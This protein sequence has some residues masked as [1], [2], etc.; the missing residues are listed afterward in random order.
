[1]F[2]VRIRRGVA[3]VALCP[4][5]REQAQRE[6]KQIKRAQR[7]TETSQLQATS[8]RQP[9]PVGQPQAETSVIRVCE[10]ASVHKGANHTRHHRTFTIAA[11]QRYADRVRG[12]RAW[13]EG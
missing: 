2:Y 9:Q 7:Q 13:P 10:F 12:S 4:P 5:S 8:Q 1:M 11:L 3:Y 6:R